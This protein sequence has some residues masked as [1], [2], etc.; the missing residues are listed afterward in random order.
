MLEGELD[1]H[2]DHN[3]HEQSSNPNSRSGYTSKKVKTA[4]GESIIQVPRDREA[5]FNPKRTNMVDSIE[6]A[7]LAAM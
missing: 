7:M 5:S 2:L 1:A 4:L 6:N 3:K